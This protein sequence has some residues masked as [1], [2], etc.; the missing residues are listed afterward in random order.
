VVVLVAAV[1][2]SG[3]DI[4]KSDIL[5]YTY[6]F[7]RICQEDSSDEI[8]RRLSKKPVPILKYDGTNLTYKTYKTSGLSSL[9]HVPVR[10][11]SGDVMYQGRKCH[12]VFLAYKEEE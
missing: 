6:N 1:K 2:F 10:N 11:F 4:K 9:G 3:R 5:G 8:Y 7:N 12:C